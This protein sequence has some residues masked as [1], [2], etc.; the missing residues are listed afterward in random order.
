VL[1]VV[2]HER[3]RRRGVGRALMRSARQLAAERWGSRRM[4]AQVSAQN[5]VGMPTS[6]LP[7]YSA[8]PLLPA[9]TPVVKIKAGARF[10]QLQAG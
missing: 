1:N 10:H 9:C 2:V 3:H 6:C 4:C 8:G 7:F 5:E